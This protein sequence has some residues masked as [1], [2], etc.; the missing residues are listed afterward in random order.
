MTT[1]ESGY[2]IIELLVVMLVIGVL[3]AMALPL[4]ELSMRRDRERELKHA[5]WEIR[6]AIDA[7]HR[8]VEAGLIPVQ[9]GQPGYPPSLATLVQGVRVGAGRAPT[10][11]LRRVPRDPFADPQLRAEETWGLRSFDSEPDAPQAGA[12]VFDI[13]SQSPLVGLN[14]VPLRAW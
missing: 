6:D 7:Y 10:Y 3:A 2:T 11:F 5:L 4:A 9:P 12:T 8:A 13:H 14:G 1:R